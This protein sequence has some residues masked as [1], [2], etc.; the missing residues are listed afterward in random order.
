L[1]EPGGLSTCPWC[2][3][4]Y[5]IYAFTLNPREPVLLMLDHLKGLKGKK[6]FSFEPTSDTIVAVLTE[7]LMIGAFYTLN[8]LPFGIVLN[9]LYESIMFLLVVLFPVWWI[10]WH[11]GQPLSELG[12][13]KKHWIPSLVISIVIF[14]FFL[15]GLWKN[16]SGNNSLWAI[17]AFCLI[18]LWEPFFVYGWLQLR[19]DRAFG[20]IPGIALAGL[21]IGIYH[22]GTYP[23]SAVFMFMVLGVVFAVIF[24]L[25]SNMLILWPLVWGASSAFSIL[26]SGF[27]FSWNEVAFMAVILLIQLGFIFY[28]WKRGKSGLPIK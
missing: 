4:D 7:L 15:S 2:R 5:I 9:L 22:I 13:T 10:V 6:W 26:M 27:T 20:I 18:G 19:F 25:T 23:L 14:L 8:H 11:R 24:R 17:L 3:N 28:T 16:Y 21:C 12:I 1:K